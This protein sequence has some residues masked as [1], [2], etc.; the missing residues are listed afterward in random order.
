MS[1]YRDKLDQI[2]E[3][4]EFS[5][6]DRRKKEFRGRGHHDPGAEDPYV[7]GI[8]KIIHDYKAAANRAELLG[9]EDEF[10]KEV[11][12][13]ITP[14]KLE[15]LNKG[16]IAEFTENDLLD[17]EWHLNR[18][19]IPMILKRSEKLSPILGSVPGEGRAK[20]TKKWYY[21]DFAIMDDGIGVKH[22]STNDFKVEVRPGF[23]PQSYIDKVKVLY[24][25]FKDAEKWL[26]SHLV[27]QVTD[28]NADASKELLSIYINKLDEA[29]NALGSGEDKSAASLASMSSIIP[30]AQK[31]EELTREYLEKINE[32]NE[33]VR[34]LYLDKQKNI[35]SSLS[36]IKT[37]GQLAQ[38][39]ERNLGDIK[40]PKGFMDVGSDKVVAVQLYNETTNHYL[41]IWI[42]LYWG[43]P[44]GILKRTTSA[45]IIQ[46]PIPGTLRQMVKREGLDAE[47]TIELR[48]T[49]ENSAMPRLADMIQTMLGE[50]VPRKELR[51]IT[52]DL[53]D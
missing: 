7:T 31:S 4:N 49:I 15:K 39:L 45:N 51:V 28:Y 6:K 30:I 17:L 23:N 18:H 52:T 41:R 36:N 11:A 38:T 5:K 37:K 34:R 22:L 47:E 2:L 21:P 46:E 32:V 19:I 40:V 20:I 24:E 13:G 53:E 25:K 1:N 35:I 44:V 16:D 33:R 8:S 9:I 29:K 10:I 12:K 3:D 27:Q 50:G 43:E 26:D 14:E 42:V 48:Q